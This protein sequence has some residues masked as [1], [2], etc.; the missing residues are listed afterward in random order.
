MDIKN[1]TKLVRPTRAEKAAGL[2]AGV[3][4]LSGMKIVR[5]HG[6]EVLPTTPEDI[7]RWRAIAIE[8]GRAPNFYA[9]EDD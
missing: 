8:E 9:G 6:P 3:D 7:A 5:C 4:P 1:G 2:K